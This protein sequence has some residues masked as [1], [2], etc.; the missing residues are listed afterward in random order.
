MS[1]VGRLCLTL[2]ADTQARLEKHAQLAGLSQA[3]MAR[4]LL[5][6]AMAARGHLAADYEAGRGEAKRL[7]ADLESPQL[8]LLDT[9][10]A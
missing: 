4:E 7:L 10:G 2:D 8:E 9:E 6:D 5:R 1:F 3:A